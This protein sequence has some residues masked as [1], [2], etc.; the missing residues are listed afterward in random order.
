M[1]NVTVGALPVGV[2]VVTLNELVTDHKE[3]DEPSQILLTAPPDTDDADQF[4]LVSDVYG[5]HSLT[6]E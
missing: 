1:L 3:V 5:I 2:P 6:S 4:P